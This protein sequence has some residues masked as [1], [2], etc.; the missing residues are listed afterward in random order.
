M[1]VPIHFAWDIKQM[2]EEYSLPA[3]DALSLDW[4]RVGH[5]KVDQVRSIA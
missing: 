3:C 2:M 4:D 1:I 5:E